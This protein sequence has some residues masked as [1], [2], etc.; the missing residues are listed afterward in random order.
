[1]KIKLYYFSGERLMNNIFYPK[2]INK[3][4]IVA[5]ENQ[6]F[7]A[8]PFST[9]YKNLYDTLSMYLHNEG[10]KCIRVDNN[11]S[12][13][14]PIINLILKGIATSQFVIVD[15][16]E[17]N[18]NVFYEL[19]ITHTIKD[20][21]NVFIIKEKDSSTP[22]DI[23]HL[24]YI[25]YDKNDLKQLAEKLLERLK[26]NQYKN[27]F[28]RELSIK[29]LLKYEDIDDFVGFFSNHFTEEEICICT[30]LLNGT[31]KVGE[32]TIITLVWKYDEIL[33]K[34][35]NIYESEESTILL[36]KLF[37]EILLSCCQ[38]PEIEVYVDEFLH[39]HDYGGLSYK[40]FLAYQTDLAIKL[41]ENLRLTEITLKWIVEY[42]QRSKSTHV[43]LNR[44]KLEAFLLKND[45]DLINEYIINALLSDNKYVREH[46]ADII[47]EKKLA[48]AEDNLITQLKRETNIYTTASIVE[49]LGKIDSKKSIVT[50]NEWLNNNAENTIKNGDYFLLKHFRNAIVKIDNDESLK[51]FDDKYFDVLK[52]NNEI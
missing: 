48:T 26:A 18:A 37:Y 41:A 51:K 6:C 44:Y 17:T 19:G 32:T 34:E 42:F 7:F 29:Q 10:Y 3:V 16:S 36:F 52:L 38:I 50:I 21:E 46:M 30:D 31:A 47:G 8:M 39:K 2:Q 20:Y 9:E 15:I 1:M 49:A 28:K 33:R 24:Q 25:S 35:T 23:Q 4:K 14:V 43:D 5:S 13:S 11:L 45:S 12:A 27:T 22:F 40:R